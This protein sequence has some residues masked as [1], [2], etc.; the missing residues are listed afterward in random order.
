MTRRAWSPVPW[1]AVLMTLAFAVGAVLA[2]AP[3]A[4]SV[5]GYNNGNNRGDNPV[6][7]SLPCQVNDP[8]MYYAMYPFLGSGCGYNLSGTPPTFTLM[9]EPDLG[10]AVLTAEGDPYG[11]LNAPSSWTCFSLSTNS[12]VVLN[13]YAVACGR[14]T[15]WEWVPP[16]YVGGHMVVQGPS[17]SSIVPIFTQFFPISLIEAAAASGP[18]SMSVTIHPPARNSALGTRSIKATATQNSLRVQHQ[19]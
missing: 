6:V 17:E 4:P 3:L 2:L 13:R 5:D 18:A 16:G 19:L 7:G 8:R 15:A 12:T 11:G 1:N 14:V 10:G 9:G